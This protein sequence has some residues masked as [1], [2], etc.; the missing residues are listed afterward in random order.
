MKMEDFYRICLRIALVLLCS[1]LIILCF[2]LPDIFTKDAHAQDVS[3]SVLE[4]KYGIYICQNPENLDS[5]AIIIPG[6]AEEAKELDEEV[7]GAVKLEGSIQ[8]VAAP[9]KKNRAQ[10]LINA[11]NFY[12]RKGK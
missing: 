11:N 6:S 10:V 8:L 7:M 12:L 5:L 2:V 1:I 9:G 3:R 4:G